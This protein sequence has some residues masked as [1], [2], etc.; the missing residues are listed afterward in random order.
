MAAGSR[1][2]KSSGMVQVVPVVTPVAMVPVRDPKAYRTVWVKASEALFIWIEMVSPK[3]PTSLVVSGQVIREGWEA[4][5]IVVRVPEPLPDFV[6]TEV[7]AKVIPNSW[8]KENEKVLLPSV[9]WAMVVV[10]L[11]RVLVALFAMPMVFV[12]LYFAP[13]I[14]TLQS[15]AAV[16]LIY[17]SLPATSCI[18]HLTVEVLPAWFWLTSSQV[19]RSVFHDVT[20]TFTIPLVAIL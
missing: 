3:F 12:P 17:P 10:P 13:L 9:L 5:G 1:F 16:E 2:M 20:V 8:E 18:V 19:K 11:A 14:V 7:P 4:L 15:F 6:P